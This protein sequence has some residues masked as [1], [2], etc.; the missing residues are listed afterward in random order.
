MH[1]GLAFASSMS[2]LFLCVLSKQIKLK[3]D[4]AEQ[5]SPPTLEK[6]ARYFMASGN[7]NLINDVMKALNRS[8]WRISQVM[9]LHLFL[10]FPFEFKQQF[11]CIF[12][13]LII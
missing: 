1:L 10:L 3:Q 9:I 13:D 5:I 8:G 6:F 7:I 12:N 4:N 11:K 2:S